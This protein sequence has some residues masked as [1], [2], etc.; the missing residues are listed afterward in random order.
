MAFTAKLHNAGAVR[1]KRLHCR[2]AAHMVTGGAVAAF[3]GDSWNHPVNL[4]TR[5]DGSRM[6]VKTAIDR[7]T[8]LYDAKG[9]AHIAR[10]G[11]GVSKSEPRAL[12]G[13]VPGDPMLDVTPLLNTNGRVRLRPGAERP[14][15]QSRRH[16][17]TPR[18][19]C[20]DSTGRGAILELDPGT[21]SE[22]LRCEQFRQGRF[23]NR[24]KRT[25]MT[26]PALRLALRGVT[27]PA[28]FGAGK[29]ACPSCGRKIE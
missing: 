14:P 16:T 15:E 8:V 11:S 4:G 2:A 18:R 22:R 17:L 26:R 27:G 29:L 1:P 13:P 3:A 7:V 10:R 25:R 23:F 20:F 28:R 9:L 5:T 6:A 12:R 19:P 21:L 24:A